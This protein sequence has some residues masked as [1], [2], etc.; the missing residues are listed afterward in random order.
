MELDIWRV[1][2]FNFCVT[3]IYAF[4]HI[5]DSASLAQILSNDMKKIQLKH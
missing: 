4:N 5:I 3:A 1:T 2:K